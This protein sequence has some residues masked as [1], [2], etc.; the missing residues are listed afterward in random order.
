MKFFNMT[1]RQRMV[2]T[3]SAITIILASI[4]GIFAF[5][6]ISRSKAEQK[7]TY[8]MAINDLA[9]E[10]YVEMLEARRR[11][12]DFQLRSNEKYIG[13]VRNHVAN[14]RKK[15]NSLKGMELTSKQKPLV[16]SLIGLIDNYEV[17]FDRMVKS[18]IDLGL[19]EF[20]A[21]LDLGVN[22]FGVGL[23]LALSEFGVSL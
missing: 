17:A 9:V 19:N 14:M 10:G 6:E 20:G 7:R 4:G 2:F 23:E 12:K 8:S 5:G 13:R 1:D 11:E 15:A 16:G 21:S 22:E 3:F 18:T